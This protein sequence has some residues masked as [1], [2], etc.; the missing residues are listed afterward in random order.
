[1]RPSLDI[2]LECE[3]AV[4]FAE[5]VKPF[6]PFFHLIVITVFQVSPALVRCPGE[7]EERLKAFIVTLV[8]TVNSLT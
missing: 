3:V 5:E 8:F 1:M 2:F 4:T 6:P 7:V